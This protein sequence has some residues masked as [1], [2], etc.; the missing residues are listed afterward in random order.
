M[1]W[2]CFILREDSNDQKNMVRRWR[3]KDQVA[4]IY[5]TR[6]YNDHGR[7]MSILSLKGEAR[8]VIL[9]PEI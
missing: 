1:E 8:S 4:N 5:G 7:Y 6:K 3:K 9:V 2:V